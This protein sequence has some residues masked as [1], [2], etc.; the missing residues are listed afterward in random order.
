ML[1]LCDESYFKG[2][3]LNSQEDVQNSNAIPNNIGIEAQYL[4]ENTLGLKYL[5]SDLSCMSVK[6][7]YSGR[8]VWPSKFHK[9]DIKINNMMPNSL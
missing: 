7:G 4:K 1:R 2:Y 8:D 6:V 9:D 3:D 5:D